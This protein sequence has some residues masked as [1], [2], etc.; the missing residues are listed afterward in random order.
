MLPIALYGVPLYWKSHNGQILNHLRRLQNTCLCL[1]TSTF[2]TTPMIAMEIE[3]SIPPINLYLEYKMDIEALRLSQ[4]DNNHP[5]I[6]RTPPD[7]LRKLPST[8]PPPT[9][10]HLIHPRKTSR[11]R[12][13]KPPPTCIS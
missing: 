5:I 9:P 7:H 10:T 11:T 13:M 12:N 4:L 6:A 1:T 8:H 3:A 2:K